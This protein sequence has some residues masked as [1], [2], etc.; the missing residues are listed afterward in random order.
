MG[1][2]QVVDTLLPKVHDLLTDNAH[3]V[4][5]IQYENIWL[6]TDFNVL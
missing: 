3:I 2:G 6:K 5:P 4:L 1:L